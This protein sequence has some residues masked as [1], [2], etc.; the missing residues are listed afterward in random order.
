MIIRLRLLLRL[1]TFWTVFFALTRWVFLLYQ[2]DLFPTLTP[3]D[4]GMITLLGLRM[5]LS[6]A[7]Y[8]TLVA[9]LVIAL[10]AV[11]PSRVTGYLIHGVNL[12]FLATS[13]L[14]IITDLE[15]Y[16]HWGY[17]IDA[18][19]LMYLRPE[20]FASA[21]TGTLVMLV[22]LWIAMAGIT[23]W[24][25]RRLIMR[26]AAL[27]HPTLS[28]TLPTL[29]AAAL[30]IIP[31]RSG[32]GIAPLNTGFVYYHRTQAFPNHAGINP[33]WNFMRSALYIDNLR[34]TEK[35]TPQHE[36]E[37]IVAGM[38]T[39]PDTTLQVIAP[40]K[41]NILLIIMEGFTSK[42]IEPLG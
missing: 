13:C 16:Q 4:W 24:A 36:A 6:M 17:R 26:Q 18:T 35:L 3:R 25:Y 19:P 15:L 41:P 37:S 30:L 32:F 23:G 8:F 14:I 20:G 11:I 34:Y 39:A 21:G 7:G 27:E 10:S 12:I 29:A 9:A 5:D 2:T 31:I 22:M 40:D 28:A 1:F 42:I 33:V 38:M